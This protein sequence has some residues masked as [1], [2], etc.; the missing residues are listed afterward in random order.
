MS[1]T[2]QVLKWDDCSTRPVLRVAFQASAS[3]S[4]NSPRDLRGFGGANLWQIVPLVDYISPKVFNVHH[5]I[6][7]NLNAN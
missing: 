7:A 6:K 5:D 1:N 4:A 2:G 3:R